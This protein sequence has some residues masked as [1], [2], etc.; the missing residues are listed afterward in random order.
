MSNMHVLTIDGAEVTL[1]MH[2]AI[3]ASNNAAGVPYRVIM[4]RF[5]GTTQLPDGDGSAGTI[6]AAERAQ[7]VAGE[8]VEAVATLKLG[9]SNPSGAQLDAFHTA[10]RSA[11]L[12][13]IQAK[14][15]CYG[16]TR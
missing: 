6:T 16:F 7:I 9:D 13:E 12:A 2:Y 15:L 5:F 1:V 10:Q 8:M 3:P 4:A 14:Y 11:F